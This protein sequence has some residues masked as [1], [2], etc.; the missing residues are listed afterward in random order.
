[1]LLW[2]REDHCSH[3]LFNNPLLLGI[4]TTTCLSFSLSLSLSLSLF[5]SLPL[6]LSQQSLSVSRSSLPPTCRLMSLLSSLSISFKSSPLDAFSLSQL[7]ILANETYPM[8]TRSTMG[9]WH[10]QGLICRVFVVVVEGIHDFRREMNLI[11]T[12]C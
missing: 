5:L 10:A 4:S 9:W 11:A 2:R 6:S 7:Y 1:M 8:K 3:H 12:L